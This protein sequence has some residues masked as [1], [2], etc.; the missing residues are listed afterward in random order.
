MNSRDELA[1]SVGRNSTWWMSVSTYSHI[2]TAIGGGHRSTA[3]RPVV[4]LLLLLIYVGSS[5]IRR[6]D[7]SSGS[8]PSPSPCSRMCSCVRD[9]DCAAGSRCYRNGT[10][11][12]QWGVIDHSL[13]YHSRSVS[14]S[15]LLQTGQRLTGFLAAGSEG[16]LPDGAIA[17]AICST[18]A[19]SPVTLQ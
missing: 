14:F 5:P 9:R 4:L 6:L 10:R 2:G 11:N 8:P 16:P 13:L 18:V 3:S 17:S 1:N 19:A 12:L 15:F 7:C